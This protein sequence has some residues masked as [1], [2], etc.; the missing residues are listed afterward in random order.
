MIL[1]CDPGC[2]RGAIPPSFSSLREDTPKAGLARVSQRST[3]LLMDLSVA[4]SAKAPAQ[5]RDEQS[6]GD[7]HV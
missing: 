1:H 5:M 2:G 6:E 4:A 7:K 3:R